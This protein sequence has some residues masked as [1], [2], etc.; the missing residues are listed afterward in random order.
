MRIKEHWQV[1]QF[2]RAAKA[3]SGSP[4]MIVQLPIAISDRRQYPGCDLCLSA[5]YAYDGKAL[6]VPGSLRCGVMLCDWSKFM[7]YLRRRNNSN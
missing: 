1:H 7:R 2:I 5:V 4:T 3:Q 6:I